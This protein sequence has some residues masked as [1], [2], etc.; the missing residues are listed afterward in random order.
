MD[1]LYV[2][3]NPNEVFEP[4]SQQTKTYSTYKQTTHTFHPRSHKSP[5]TSRMPLR[6][7]LH[8]HSCISPCT[9]ASNAFPDT[10]VR[11]HRTALVRTT[12]REDKSA[13][14]SWRNRAFGRGIVSTHGRGCGDLDPMLLP[15]PMS[16]AG[17]SSVSTGKSCWSHAR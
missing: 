5:S 15:L 2:S 7:N 10:P 4:G 12:V 17:S 3:R 16:C 9:P 11:N 6:A 13:S 1:I 8:R 14:T